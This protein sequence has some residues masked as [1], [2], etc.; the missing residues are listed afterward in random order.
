[1]RS[2]LIFIDQPKSAAQKMIER[3]NLVVQDP[4]R[5]KYKTSPIKNVKEE[6][7]YKFMKRWKAL[8]LVEK[9]LSFESCEKKEIL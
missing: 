3:L 2:S 1:M 8:L 6:A 5:R 9:L 4:R 7:R